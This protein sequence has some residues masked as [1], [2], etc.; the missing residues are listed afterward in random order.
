SE[1]QG[2]G[3]GQR[4]AD[5]DLLLPIEHAAVD[6]PLPITVAT[7]SHFA[8]L[9]TLPSRPAPLDFDISALAPMDAESELRKAV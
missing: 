2:E 9:Y 7:P 8:E 1:G 6:L 4:D 5:I 3:E